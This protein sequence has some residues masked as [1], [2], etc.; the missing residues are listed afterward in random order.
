MRDHCHVTGKYGGSAHTDCNLSY[1]L[2]NKIYVIFY[3]LR[4]YD[5]PLIMQEIGKFN[6]DIN[7]IPNNMEKY[8]AFMINRNLIFIDSFQFMNQSLSNLANNLP[9]DGFYHTKKEFGTEN[10]ELITRKGVYPYDYMDDFN[11]F[12]EKRATINRKFL[13]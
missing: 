2:T 3:N 12:K 11:K 5:L 4:C 10:L 13:F 1:R 7:V 6:K 9:K 8:M